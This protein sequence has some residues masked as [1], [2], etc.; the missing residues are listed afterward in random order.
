M[1]T[2]IGAQ[3]TK[4]WVRTLLLL[5]YGLIVAAIG[6]ALVLPDLPSDD[7]WPLLRDNGPFAASIEQL[8]AG[9]PPL[10]Q[11]N[12]QVDGG[13]PYAGVPS[14][15][16]L[17]EL[18]RATEEGASYAR[19]LTRAGGRDDA[20]SDATAL[21]EDVSPTEPAAGEPQYQ[22]IN[23]G[24]E[25]GVFVAVPLVA[26][27]FDLSTTG[28][29]RLLYLLLFI[30]LIAIYPL[31]FERVTRS[32][33]AAAVAP[34]GLI[35]ALLHGSFETDMYWVQAW[36]V[37]AL[38]PLVWLLSTRETWGRKA[39]LLLAG[40]G[41]AA[42]FA[43]S[44][45]GLSGV[46]IVLAAWIVIALRKEI[47]KLRRGG[48]AVLLLVAYL[49]VIP[50][51]TGLVRAYAEHWGEDNGGLADSPRP[52]SN[53]IWHTAY[54]GLGWLPND[55]G[56]IYSDFVAYLKVHQAEPD[57][58]LFSPDYASALRTLYLDAIKDDPAGFAE[59]ETKKSISAFHDHSSQLIILIFLV[60]LAL[61][62]TGVR[63]D[64]WRCVWLTLPAL[65][66]GLSQGLLAIPTPYYV[67]GFNGA[68]IMLGLMMGAL[69]AAEAERRL[70]AYRREG[71]APALSSLVT[72]PVA[73]I[74][75]AV[76]LLSVW[77]SGRALG[78]DYQEENT[79]WSANSP[80]TIAMRRAMALR[81]STLEAD[82]DAA[83]RLAQPGPGGD[84]PRAIGLE[85]AAGKLS[86]ELEPYANGGSQTFEGWARQESPEVGGGLISSPNLLRPPIFR[87]VA[88]TE[89][90]QFFTANGGFANWPGA[91]PGAGKWVHWALVFDQ[92]AGTAELF[93]NGESR[94]EQPQPQPYDDEAG[95]YQAGAWGLYKNEPFLGGL[96]GL[97]VYDEALDADA[98]A[99]HYEAAERGYDDAV[100]VDAPELY[101]KLDERRGIIIRDSSGNGN[102]G[103]IV[104]YG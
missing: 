55:D 88:G 62:L 52:P 13:S 47:P 2:G 23:F 91:W 103:E 70:R 17:D 63:H 31:I 34:I 72:S 10:I 90:V 92:P 35:V 77:Y 102:D 84:L 65:L 40:I 29:M 54:I 85:G 81:S 14:D 30:P 87:I 74:V 104:W 15:A 41:V 97:A 73:S 26:H 80:T 67:L 38:L 9:A 33:L 99:A 1:G 76:A 51:G 50:V 96:A 68:L 22:T 5:V 61:L 43:S 44:L 12:Q 8:D 48:L 58:S 46:A 95:S 83:Y 36:A 59:L 101:W 53:F 64:V 6:L 39:V 93:I 69:I 89:D 28:A 4:R 7:E 78:A 20:G 75:V 98:I 49:S 42:S 60:P 16:A 86:S 19:E 56:I 24:G 32:L 3:L 94:G 45:R 82:Q 25:A 71:T 27:W 21:P 79:T 57:A 11:A 37:L 100:L 18:F 66:I